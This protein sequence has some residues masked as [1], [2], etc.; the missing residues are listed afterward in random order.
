MGLLQKTDRVPV[1]NSLILRL[2]A[3]WRHLAIVAPFG[4]GFFAVILAFNPKSFSVR[5]ILLTEKVIPDSVK[6]D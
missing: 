1:L 2:F 4:L 6:S 3:H 5:L